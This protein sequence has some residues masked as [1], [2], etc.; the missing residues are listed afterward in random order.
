MGICR[1]AEVS[2]LDRLYHD[3]EWGVPEYDEVRL[4][5]LLTLEGAEAG[6]SWSIILHKREGYRRLFEGFDVEKVAR[7]T[8]KRIE[9]LAADPAIVRHRGKIASV[10]E[11]AKAILR[12]EEEGTTLGTLLWDLAGG[13]PRTN[14]WKTME[15]VPASTP[16]STAMSKTLKKRGFTFV[17]PTTCYALMQAAGMVNDHLTTCFRHREISQKKGS[18]PNR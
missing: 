5:E 1:W 15:E 17:G 14:R 6:L 13:A 2:E 18:H 12:L 4:F 11:N 9:R 10:V 3:V 16:E 8:P 7:F